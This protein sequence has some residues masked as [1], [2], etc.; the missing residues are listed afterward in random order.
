MRRDPPSANLPWLVTSGQQDPQTVDRLLRSLPEWFG[1][2]SSNI[3]YV[4]AAARLPTYLAWPAGDLPAPGQQRQA[5]GV[6]LAARH[7]PAAAEIY[8][9]AVDPAT[10]RR[11]V[12]RALV[13]ALERDL[14]ADGV[15]IMEV[16][17]LGPSDPDGGYRRTRLF[18][19]GMGF[20]PVEEIAGLWPG[21]PCLIMIK[22]LALCRRSRA[23]AVRDHREF[24]ARGPQDAD[25]GAERLA[26]QV[27]PQHVGRLAVGRHLAV[28]EQDEPVGELPGQ[29][30]VVDRGEHAEGPLP[31]QFVDQLKGIDPAAE[32]ERA[33]R[34]VEHQDR[35][36]LGQGAGE[37]QPLRLASRHRSD[38]ATSHVGQRH[39]VE[40]VQADSPVPLGLHGKV[41]Q[42]RRPPEQD[43]VKAGHVGR[44][45]GMLRHIRDEPGAPAVAEL[46]AGL[47]GQ[48]DAAGRVRQPGDGPEHGGLARAVRSDQRDPFAGRHRDADTVQGGGGAETDPQVIDADHDVSA[49]A[50]RERSTKRKNGAP[51]AAVMTP[52]GTSVSGCTVLAAMSASTRNAAP[53]IIETGTMIR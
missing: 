42:V 49:L 37:D 52:I 3:G 18:Y 1:I 5:V 26:E 28:A 29:G 34:L 31:A 24:P 45:L 40:Q 12:G 13:E 19:Q 36:L 35:R 2:E 8:L 15:R 47:A 7:F 46:P 23:L 10:H 16:K 14:V 21:V 32:I 41:A 39:P 38:T 44:Q 43:V 51:I 33:R 11:G 17:T 25:P 6:L 27:I 48:N 20:E 4:E 9:L 30:E 50:R 22:V 53:P